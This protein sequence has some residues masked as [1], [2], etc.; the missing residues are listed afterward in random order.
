MSSLD[1]LDKYVFDESEFFNEYDSSSFIMISNSVLNK[2]IA[3]FLVFIKDTESTTLLESAI[4][5]LN[6]IDVE[7][8]AMTE[9]MTKILGSSKVDRAGLMMK[10]ITKNGKINVKMQYLKEA[11]NDLKY[12]INDLLSGKID[13]DSA[14]VNI[15]TMTASSYKDKL[16][17]RTVE[18]YNIP[19]IDDPKKFISNVSYISTPLT[20]QYLNSV[21]IPY[22]ENFQKTKVAIT[23]ETNLI[24]REIS[25]DISELSLTMKTLNSVN[26]PDDKKSII[27][28]YCYN[29]VRTILEVIKYV[30]YCQMRKIHIIEENI[31]AIQEAYNKLMLLFASET[32]LVEAGAYDT[33]IITAAD[34]NN[35]IEAIFNGQ[36]DAFIEL[37]NSI[38]EY[39]KGYIFDKFGMDKSDSDII[40]AKII[41]DDTY[42]KDIYNDI[43]KVYIEIGN[44]LDILAKNSDDYLMVFDDLKNKSGFVVPLPERFKT[45]IDRIKELSNYGLTNISIG[46]GG[47]KTDIYFKILSEIIDYPKNMER[48]AKTVCD[49]WQKFEYVDKLFTSKAN[50][51]LAYSETMNELKILLESLKEQYKIITKSITDNMYLRLKLLSEKADQC[52]DN[53]SSEDKTNIEELIPTPNRNFMGEATL[54]IIDVQN[55]FTDLY[56]DIY[57]KEYYSEREYLEKGVRLVYEA[58]GDTNNNTANQNKPDTHVVVNDNPEAKNSTS[59][60]KLDRGK[61]SNILKT[62]GEWFKKMVAAFIN[63]INRYKAKNTDWLA[64]HK[65]GLLTRSYSNVQ[66][67]ILPYDRGPTTQKIDQDITSFIT[68]LNTMT[69]DNIAK[70]N[71]YED[72]RS[73]LITGGIIF[74]AN[75]DEKATITR[76]YKVGN[77]KLETVKYSNNEIKTYVSQHMIPYCEV[78]YTTYYDSLNKKLKGVEKSMEDVIKTYATEAFADLAS[79]SSIFYEEGEQNTSGT[80][81]TTTVTTTTGSTNT[82][83]NNNGGTNITQKTGWIQTCVRNYIGCILTAIRDRNNDYLKVLFALAPKTVTT[84]NTNKKND[85]GAPETEDNTPVQ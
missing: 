42:D 59:S 41:E 55:A 72:L 10:D 7:S 4:R 47:E 84:T 81:T 82:N 39:H 31:T 53:V 20:I 83:Q 49:M 24:I 2:K 30:T 66:I 26:I 8:Y 50:G 25:N 15:K 61:L 57:M 28:N 33:R 6:N 35:L 36:I 52:L 14:I 22:V 54:G 70:V 21:I 11:V 75:E 73:K 76:Y 1:L 32:S 5:N 63:M 74:N 16:K 77:N 64:K 58:D 44:G 12:N 19:Y 51:E 43:V 78:F 65:D 79:G 45:E 18:I 85:N 56:M 38:I 80:N 9:F 69:K 48:I 71:T 34:G 23:T 60:K 27:L 37:S 68:N 46:S 17:Q 67:D 40:M 29:T 62:I 13:A 3:D